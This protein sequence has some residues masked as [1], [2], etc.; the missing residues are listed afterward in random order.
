M[1]KHFQIME[2]A[3]LLETIGTRFPLTPDSFMGGRS[4]LEHWL[5]RE[6]N[7][8]YRDNRKLREENKKSILD[9]I[10]FFGA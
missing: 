3:F 5:Q 7:L 6:G 10:F 4:M 1:K 8:Q 2:A 9:C